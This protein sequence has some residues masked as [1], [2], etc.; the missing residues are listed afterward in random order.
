MELG[1]G[2]VVLL[3]SAYWHAACGQPACGPCLSLA[4]QLAALH[5]WPSF[6]CARSESHPIRVS[7]YMMSII[8]TT[9]EEL[10]EDGI[11][12]PLLD[13]ILENLLPAR[14]SEKPA[15][16]HLARQVLERCAVCRTP[17]NAAPPCSPRRHLPSPDWPRCLGSPR[18]R[19]AASPMAGLPAA[20]PCLPCLPANYPYCT[21]YR[22]TSSSPCKSSSRAACPRAAA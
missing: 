11:P 2:F 13:A 8:V 3:A 10:A 4:Q 7:N 21:C 22:T 17:R 19:V 14:R 5:T 9:L 18:C 16:Y 15:S 6:W 12:T 20:V 1:E